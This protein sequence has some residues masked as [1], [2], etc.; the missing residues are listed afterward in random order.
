MRWGSVIL[1]ALFE[2]GW[3]MGLKHADSALEWICTAAAS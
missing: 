3:V 2:I 1:A